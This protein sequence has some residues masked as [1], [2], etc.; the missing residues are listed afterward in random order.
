MYTRHCSKYFTRI[1][2]FNPSTT[3]GVGIMN[4]P[5]LH[6]RK[7]REVKYFPKIMHLAGGSAREV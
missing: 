6:M 2:S 5:I 3:L 7:L 1:N 4:I